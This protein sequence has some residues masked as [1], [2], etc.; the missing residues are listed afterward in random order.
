MR[1]PKFLEKKAGNIHTNF[2]LKRI[3]PHIILMM[4]E[5]KATEEFPKVDITLEQDGGVIK[6]I[7]RD[8]QGEDRPC[9]GDTVSVHYVGCLDDGTE[10]DS[11]RSREQLF[12]F[13][14]GKGLISHQNE[15]IS[16][17]RQ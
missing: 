16:H 11:S 5:G 14:L 10:F 12:T 7:L 9:T 15:H 17:I 2:F 4:P 8:G 13:E 6:Q 1:D 3:S